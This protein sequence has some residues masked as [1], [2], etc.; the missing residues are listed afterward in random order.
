[1]CFS[2][3][4]EVF[5]EIRDTNVRVRRT[6]KKKKNNRESEQRI[7]QINRFKRARRPLICSDTKIRSLSRDVSLDR[8]TSTS[9]PRYRE[10][11][12]STIAAGRLIELMQQNALFGIA[13]P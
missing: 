10:H 4:R 1:M 12:L 5:D 8:L 3:A 9:L 7:Y 6:E 13:A 2:F 11:S